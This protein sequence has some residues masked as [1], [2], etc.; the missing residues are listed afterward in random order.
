M[1]EP[2]TR[3]TADFEPGPVV[4]RGRRRLDPA[5]IV[6]TVV[7]I[8]LVV[9]VVKPWEPAAR[10]GASPPAPSERP[11]P[12]APAAAPTTAL[13]PIDPTDRATVAHA[14]ASLT[15]RDAWGIRTLTTSLGVTGPSPFIERWQPAKPTGFTGI[16]PLR[17]TSE[18]PIAFIGLTTPVDQAALDIRAWARGHDGAWHW[19]A[20]R[21]L[22]SQLPAADLLLPPP[23]VDGKVLP[24]WPVGR[25]RFDLLLG[26]SIERID[27]S[28]GPGAANADAPVSRP[29]AASAP[30]E[31]SWPDVIG[32]GPYAVVD[33]EVRPLA[34]FGRDQLEVAEAWLAGDQVARAWLPAASELGV[35]LPA[36]AASPSGVIRRLAP[37]PV[38]LGPV[39][40]QGVQQGPNG[41]ARPYVGFADASGLLIQPGV[42]GMDIAWTDGGARQAASWYVELLPGPRVRGGSPLFMAARRFPGYAEP[43]GVVIAPSVE[44]SVDPI[45]PVLPSVPMS[46]VIG[47]SGEVIDGA[48][49][50]IGVGHMPDRLPDRITATI[51]PSG[52]SDGPGEGPFPVRTY[53]L[54]IAPSVAPGL[55]LIAPAD[56][57]AFLP[58]TYRFG[59]DYGAD[60]R[61][62]FTICVGGAPPGG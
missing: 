11:S 38:F 54:R 14:L 16:A 5:L 25:Y 28:V 60:G 41:E 58:G 45:G 10:P 59:L 32:P 62:T 3:E 39:A 19:L 2:E 33:G 42:Y 15:T 24:A 7:V 1:I 21:R 44:G 43:D 56:D 23:E 48:I 12:S 50:V 31:T 36:G 53:P 40:H 57:P 9:A 46:G 18:T 52:S 34:G 47:C 51:A 29:P 26:Q 4:P 20:L 22:S 13:G 61:R 30:G 27:L 6:A 8:A 49:T 37:D 55:T 35:L 17:V